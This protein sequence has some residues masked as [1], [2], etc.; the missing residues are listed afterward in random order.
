[1]DHYNGLAES[2]RVLKIDGK[3]LITG[4][5]DNYFKDDK[6]AFIAEKNAFLKSFPNHFVDME[7]LLNN[8]DELGFLLEKLFIFPRRGDF[9]KIEYIEINLPFENINGYEYLMVLKKVKS[10]QRSSYRTL[11]N[12]HSKTSQLI[13]NENGYNCVKEYFI[14][15]GIY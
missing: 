10:I 11:D 4:K 8:I 13:A 5:I 15:L 3:I 9:G 1:V 6:N 12:P 2:N 14:Q 7:L